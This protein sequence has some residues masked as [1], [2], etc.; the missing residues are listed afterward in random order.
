MSSGLITNGGHSA[1]DGITSDISCIS[2]FANTWLRIDLD[3]TMKVH[4]IILHPGSQRE[5]ERV[6][7]A[8]FETI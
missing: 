4:A 1:V 3:T 2:L 6:F 7:E 5:F 8:L